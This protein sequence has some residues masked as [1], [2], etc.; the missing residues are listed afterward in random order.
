MVHQH[1]GDSSALKGVESSAL[2]QPGDHTVHL[3]TAVCRR[4]VNQ[5]NQQWT[6]HF[7]SWGHRLRATSQSVDL[8]ARELS[9][10]TTNKVFLHGVPVHGISS[11][12]SSSSLSW[13]DSSADPVKGEV[14]KV[15]Q[16]ME[17]CTA[18]P[19]CPKQHKKSLVKQLAAIQLP[20]ERITS[21][22]STDYTVLTSR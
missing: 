21:L 13:W 16:W 15:H 4:V 19:K 17:H 6:K 12:F 22:W 20:L 1:T 8:T 11:L 14:G 7:T 3:T 10:D 2:C 5:W 18:L 9:L